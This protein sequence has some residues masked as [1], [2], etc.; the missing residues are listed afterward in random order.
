MNDLGNP[1]AVPV[2]K[3]EYDRIREKAVGG[4]GM[5]SA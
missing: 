4:A 5:A 3:Q 2:P 1:G